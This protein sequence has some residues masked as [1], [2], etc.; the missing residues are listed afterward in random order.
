[1]N[2]GYSRNVNK[3]F[4]LPIGHDIVF[5]SSIYLNKQYKYCWCKKIFLLFIKKIN[6]WKLYSL[7]MANDLHHF[8][9]LKRLLT[10]LLQPL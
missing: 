2:G 10:L 4:F 6:L 3:G 9:L 1:M 7:V 8:N 5:L